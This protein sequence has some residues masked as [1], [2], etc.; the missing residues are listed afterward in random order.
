MEASSCQD[1]LARTRR[2]CESQV[3]AAAQR[4]R[5]AAAECEC[6]RARKR[7]AVA[8]AQD[9]QRREQQAASHARAVSAEHAAA[10]EHINDLR[11][12]VCPGRRRHDV[13]LMHALLII[14]CKHSGAK[15]A[16]SATS[17]PS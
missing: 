3:E 15:L 7:E 9:A 1:E 10:Q 4:Q 16:S 5:D 2:V 11:E 8:L 14:S 13:H 6:A 12:A 17:I